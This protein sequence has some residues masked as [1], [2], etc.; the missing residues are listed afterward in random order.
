MRTHAAVPLVAVL[1][2]LLAIPAVADAATPKACDLLSAQTATSLLGAAVG[3]PTD[4]KGATCT[5]VCTSGN[6]TIALGIADSSGTDGAHDIQVLQM[7]ASQEKG[8]TTKS[9]AGLG[10]QSFLVTRTSNKNAI[11]LVYHQKML[12]LAV[13]RPM[14]PELEKAMVQTLRQVLAKL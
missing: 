9:I 8:T 11:V 3:K 1:F 12:T 4:M 7:M 2:S 10:E 6:A 14:T 13:Q 5:Y